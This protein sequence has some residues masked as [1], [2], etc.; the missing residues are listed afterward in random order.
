[1]TLT[2]AR[3]VAADAAPVASRHHEGH[4]EGSSGH[5]IEL[6]VS[7]DAAVPSCRA[8]QQ[9]DAFVHCSASGW[10]PAGALAGRVAATAETIASM[11]VA[12]RASVRIRFMTD[13]LC[14]TSRVPEIV[15]ISGGIDQA[16]RV[17]GGARAGGRRDHGA[18][19]GRVRGSIGAGE[20]SLGGV[21]A[22]LGT[23]SDECESAPGSAGARTTTRASGSAST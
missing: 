10:A 2:G 1:M 13:L 16:F 17:A 5:S 8:R 21:S 18:V 9:A 12:A 22:R 6:F 15:A 4:C 7:L 19:G 14:R 3:L 20:H 11:A 23:T